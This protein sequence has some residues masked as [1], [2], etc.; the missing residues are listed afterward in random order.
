MLGKHYFYR[1]KMAST[2]KGKAP[3]RTNNIEEISN[4]TLQSDDE[5][6]DLSDSD[7]DDNL[8]A[9]DLSSDSSESG[10]DEEMIHLSVNTDEPGPSTSN[11]RKTVSNTGPKQRK[12]AAKNISKY[13]NVKWTET[14]PTPAMRRH[15]FVG[16]EPG[17]TEHVTS[18]EPID[19]FEIFVTDDLI[20]L[21]VENT[22]LYA[23]QSMEGKEYARTSRLFKWEPVTAAEIRLYIA[24]LIYRG[25]VYKPR[26]HL[27]YTKN[28]LFQTPGF[29]RILSQNKLVLLEKFLH[30]CNNQELPENYNKTAKIQPVLEMLNKRFKLLIN[31]ERDLSIDESL[32]LWKGRL[33][34]KQY[35][36]KKRSRFGTK[37]FVLCEA[38][39][40][41]IW[42]ITLY[43]GADTLGIDPNG[44]EEYHAT[45]VVLYLSDGIFDNGHCVYID[46]W[47][48]SIEI[49]DILN[50]RSTDVVGTIRRDR[51]GLPTDVSKK[52]LGPG[53]RTVMYEHTLGLLLPIGKIKEMSLCSPHVLQ[54]VKQ[55]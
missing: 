32:L 18:N 19:I 22:N 24:V 48:T 27:Y 47:Y 40:G 52:K 31:L 4:F 43:S 45:K 55:M 2:K 39:T 21:I 50:K 8:D 33:S 46:N 9:T 35:I 12:R 14:E 38:S 3:E 36:P 49:C 25:L 6:S 42:N 29:R 34:W 26:E 51:K 16:D 41:Y 30:F 44:I 1:S 7:Y 5:L 17:V 28:K 53:E 23:A 13:S 37:S 11:K 54:M 10:N 15:E 20:E